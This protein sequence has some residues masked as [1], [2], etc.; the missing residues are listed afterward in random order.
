MIVEFR[1]AP[2]QVVEV[3]DR[4]AHADGSRECRPVAP[5]YKAAV[6]DAVFAAA[7]A[8][9][10][11]SYMYAGSLADEAPA[12]L[13]TID[14]REVHGEFSIG[15]EL[16]PCLSKLIEETGEL[17]QVA[18]K[19]I[20]AEG[21]TIHFDGSDLRERMVEEMADVLAAID[22]VIEL[23]GLPIGDVQ[24]RRYYKRELFRG[25]HADGI[26][27]RQAEVIA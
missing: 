20:G 12:D 13:V 11:P 1:R 27:K 7:I 9:P 17:G 21:A 6:V 16:W 2:I 4:F 24:R 10:E 18:G 8:D 25:W 23:N 15:G 14:L 22:V 3:V 19:I 5:E 26:A